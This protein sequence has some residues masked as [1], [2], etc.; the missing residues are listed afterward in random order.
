MKFGF[1][2][3]VKSRS[4]S[5]LILSLAS[6]HCWSSGVGGRCILLELLGV[7]DALPVLR[8]WW[9]GGGPQQEGSGGPGHP[10][11]ALFL[12]CPYNLFLQP[13]CFH[14]KMEIFPTGSFEMKSWARRLN[15][16]P[17][18]VLE[19]LDLC[20]AG[21]CGAQPCRTP[22]APEASLCWS[23]GAGCRAELRAEFS[24]AS[25]RV[26]VSPSPSI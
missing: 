26:E 7:A 9:P 11:T 22:T 19:L 2:Q 5:Q 8:G 24:C 18:L 14:D 23:T 25:Q 4:G 16:A 12:R 21:G 1:Q 13:S 15:V 6:P 17:S 10:T 20:S 3:D